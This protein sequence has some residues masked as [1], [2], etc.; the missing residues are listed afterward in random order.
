MG[1]AWG[2]KYVVSSKWLLGLYL[3]VVAHVLWVLIVALQPNGSIFTFADTQVA[4]FLTGFY[5]PEEASDGTLYRWSSGTSTI[6]NPSAPDDVSAIWRVSIAASTKATPMYINGSRTMHSGARTYA[7]MGTPQTW[8]IASLTMST[9]TFADPQEART[10][11]VRVIR[12]TVMQVKQHR[13]NLLVYLS[14]MVLVLSLAL[15][16]WVMGGRARALAGALVIGMV[17]VTLC[18]RIDPRASGLWLRDIA[19]VLAG[20]PVALW[21]LRRWFPISLLLG[22]ASLF[23]LR[24]WGIANPNFEGHDYRIHLR[25]LSDFASGIWTLSAH[26]YEFGRRE[27]IILPLYYRLAD[28]FSALLGTH[29]ALHLII[30]MAET[31]IALVVWLLIRHAA[32]PARTAL[33][34]AFVV[35]LMPLSSSVLYWSFMQQIS[36]HVFTFAIAYLTSNGSRRAVWLAGILLAIVALTHIGEAFIAA[37]WYLAIR[38]SEPDRFTRVWWLKTLPA[39]LAGVAVLPL[40]WSFLGRIGASGSNL[41]QPSNTEIAQQLQIAFTVGLAPIPLF[42]AGIVVALLLV[43]KP[44]MALPWVSVVGFFLAVEV[45][46]RAQVRYLYTGAPLVAVALGWCIAPLWRKGIAARVFVVLIIGFLGWV[47]SALWIDAVLG[48]QKPRIDGLTH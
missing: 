22:W 12:A 44:R 33:I 27:S 40:Y 8:G 17:I 38:F 46:T 5:A 2:L 39:T 36:A 45:A 19:V 29:L 13:P 24:V 42:A 6:R 4:P 23:V 48:L 30:V 1:M 20:L 15:S 43:Q 35:L 9:A 7:V 11:G 14:S 34:A 32:F 21:V 37:V 16:A 25:R 31:S 18:L 26:P 47:T 3:V 28:A 10:L 41:V